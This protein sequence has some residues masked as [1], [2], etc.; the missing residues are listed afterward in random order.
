[1][2]L[3]VPSDHLQGELVLRIFVVGEHQAEL[4]QVPEL[5]RQPDVGVLERNAGCSFQVIGEQCAEGHA[6]LVVLEDGLVRFQ[7]ERWG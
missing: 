4:E 5:V 6:S 1:M 3:V 7:V 2:L